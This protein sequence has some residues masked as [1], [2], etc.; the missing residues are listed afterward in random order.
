MVEIREP[1]HDPMADRWVRG[2]IT[3]EE[4]KAHVLAKHRAREQQLAAVQA[5]AAPPKRRHWWSRLGL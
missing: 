1:L 4:W 2:E 3:N 5:Q